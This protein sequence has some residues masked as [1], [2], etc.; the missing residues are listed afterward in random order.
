M[1]G[2]TFLRYE[3]WV[4]DFRYVHP[5]RQAYM[6]EAMAMSQCRGPALLGEQRILIQLPA[7]S[8]SLRAQLGAAASLNYVAAI[9]A[10]PSASEIVGAQFGSAGSG[11]VCITSRAR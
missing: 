10:R 5:G 1:L 7:E 8:K 3:N 2:F 4:P 9:F 11:G 6:V